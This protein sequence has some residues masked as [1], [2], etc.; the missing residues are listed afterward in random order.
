MV[1]YYTSTHIQG[2]RLEYKHENG[3][4]FEWDTAHLCGLKETPSK[5]RLHMET[6]TADQEL[7]KKTVVSEF[8]LVSIRMFEF[9]EFTET[10]SENSKKRRK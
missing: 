10:K 6:L 9:F 1:T 3:S 8:K 4:L 5:L 7:L 2:G